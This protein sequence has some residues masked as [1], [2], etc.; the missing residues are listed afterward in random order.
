MLIEQFDLGET[1][2]HDIPIL[3]KDGKTPLEGR[4]HEFSAKKAE[5]LARH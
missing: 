3:G 1:R 5:L 4:W 2:F